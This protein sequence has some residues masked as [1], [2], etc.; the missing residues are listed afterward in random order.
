[1]SPK[2]RQ[3]GFMSGS[4]NI[5]GGQLQQGETRTVGIR[6]GV[7]PQRGGKSDSPQAALIVVS[8]QAKT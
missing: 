1:M 2:R 4:W 5:L 6:G 3:G 7:F 8:R